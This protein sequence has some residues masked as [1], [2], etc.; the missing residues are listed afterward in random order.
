MSAE[1]GTVHHT[2]SFLDSAF[3]R[4]VALLIAA[5]GIALFVWVNFD[6]LN[7][8][9][10]LDSTLATPYDE[11]LD[12]RMA[13]VEELAKEANFNAKQTELAKIRAVK[14]RELGKG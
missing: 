11:C 5:G 4:L 12:E 2:A 3:A 9:L 1:T 10:G 14:R 6:F 7:D 8:K 13:S